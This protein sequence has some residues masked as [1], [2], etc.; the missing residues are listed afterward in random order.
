MNI[1]IV[2]DDPMVQFIHRN[3]LEKIAS[4]SAIY[5]CETISEARDIVKN[6]TVDL[7][8]LD[9][10]LK[11]GNGVDFLTEI[12]HHQYNIEMI[13]ITAANESYI[14]AQG[15][16]LGILDYLIKPFSFERFEQSIRIF[17]QKHRQLVQP[18]I[19]QKQI[20]QMLGTSTQEELDIQEEKGISHQTLSLLLE[21]I[22]SFQHSFTVQE[23]SEASDLS[24]VSVRK[25][26][27]F[28]EKKGIIESENVYLKI[29]RPY[30]NYRLIKDL[31][32]ISFNE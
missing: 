32:T 12:R 3:Y 21:K 20:D 10:N 4:F 24:H 16:H 29:G 27:T 1:L 31:I 15:F 6:K 30:K 17:M 26:V 7:V 2:E 13:L 19:N 28:L 22:Q 5:S 23:L 14:V 18:Y 8:L 11:D 25:Y 9:I